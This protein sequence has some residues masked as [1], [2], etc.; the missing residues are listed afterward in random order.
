MTKS[1]D[2]Q[3]AEWVGQTEDDIKFVAAEATQDLMEAAQT[4]QHGVKVTGGSFEIG[5]IPVD[6]HD[7]IN[8]L[9]S[10]LN[11]SPVDEGE[12]CYGV[13]ISGFELGDEI[14]FEWTAQ[15][16]LPIDQ[17]FTAENGTQVPGRHF[18]G[19][20]VGRWQEFVDGAVARAR[21]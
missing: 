9:K 12:F 18:V 15:H 4:P 8:S 20:N 10:S 3:I 21:K 1:F 13:A 14:S 17:G 19:Y 7:L 16:A 2:L 5:K 11:G 6:D